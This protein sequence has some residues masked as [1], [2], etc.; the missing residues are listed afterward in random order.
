MR[1]LSDEPLPPPGATIAVGAERGVFQPDL[2]PL[3]FTATQVQFGSRYYS[4]IGC[5]RCH[6]G[7][8]AGLQD[9]EAGA[10]ALVGRA[11]AENWF[12][13]NVDELYRYIALEMPADF[14][15][16]ARGIDDSYLLTIV[17]FILERN[18][19]LAGDIEMPADRAGQ[20]AMGFYQ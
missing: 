4:Q 7:N 17:A 3:A 12:G 20:R 15:I 18:G 14:T 11:F 6:A 19:F 2:E 8:L 16:S 13:G 9:S 1:T 5:D 10:P